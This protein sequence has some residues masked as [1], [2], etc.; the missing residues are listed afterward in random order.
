MEHV[1]PYLKNLQWV[2][3]IGTGVENL[4]KCPTL[5]NSD[6]ITLTNMR[7]V[8]SVLLA[9]FA[10]MAI[11]YFYKRIPIFQ[12]VFRKKQV[13]Q[14]RVVRSVSDM[15]VLVVGIGSI[16]R[17]CALKCK[18]GLN[19]KVWGVKRDISN[20]KHLEGLVEGVIALEKLRESIGE[21]DVVI[22]A[23]PF[24]QDKKIFTDDV[25][26]SMKEGAVFINV[27]RGVYVDE[28]A[29]IKHL[30][31]GHLLG[32]GLDVINN[33][34]I[35]HDSPFYD[36][37]LKDRLFYSFHH[38]DTS[39][40]LDRRTRVLT[41]ENIENYLNDRPLQRVVNKKFGY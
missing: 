34:P 17:E 25:F 3:A 1:T 28:D 19:M 12:E 2:M 31:N 40:D 35:P 14:E 37:R 39:V 33:E 10:M 11:L 18:Y 24:I 36:T 26:A 5:R 32:A 38:M 6:H 4:V 8:S 7:S 21:F 20:A 9:E 23:L 22:A 27:G 16:G 15:K 13:M 29:L 30:V 41:R